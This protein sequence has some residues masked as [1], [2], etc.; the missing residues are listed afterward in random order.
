MALWMVAA[1]CVGCVAAKR[2]GEGDTGVTPGFK[3]S[4]DDETIFLR[5]EGVVC[6]EESVDVVAA[7]DFFGFSCIDPTKNHQKWTLAFSP[8]ED[9]VP[10]TAKCEPSN[11]FYV[12]SFKKVHRHYFDR[13]WVPANDEEL[14]K[15]GKVNWKAMNSVENEDFD[16]YSSRSI[17]TLDAKQLEK[18]HKKANKKQLA[19]ILD[20][21]YPWCTKC[22]NQRET[23]DAASKKL[24]KKALFGYIDAREN[25]KLGRDFDADCTAK[26][27][28]FIFPPGEVNHTFVEIKEDGTSAKFLTELEGYLKPAVSYINSAKVLRKMFSEYPGVVVSTYKTNENIEELLQNAAKVYRNIAFVV[29]NG[30]LKGLKANGL[31]GV[32][33]KGKEKIKYDGLDAESNFSVDTEGEKLAIWAQ[34]MAIPYFQMFSLEGVI[35]LRE[36]FKK[37]QIP[38]AKV[39]ADEDNLPEG[40]DRV[41]FINTFKKVA[42]KYHG[43]IS[44]LYYNADIDRVQMEESGLPDH[45]YPNLAIYTSYDGQPADNERYAYIKGVV[46]KD[47]SEDSIREF[48][49]DFL[50]GKL[51]PTYKSKDLEPQTYEKG[52]VIEISYASLF[53]R[54]F[55]T[56]KESPGDAL[57]LL[58]K[59]WSPKKDKYLKMLDHIA[60]VLQDLDFTVGHYD[61]FANYDDRKAW[62]NENRFWNNAMLYLVQDASN[63]EPILIAQDED[64]DNKFSFSNVLRDLKK[65]NKQVEDAWD[66]VRS[67]IPEVREILAEEKAKKEREKEEA[68]KKT[69][70]EAEKFNQKLQEYPK[71][72]LTPEHSMVSEGVLKYTFEEG[73]GGEAPPKGS[74]VV[75]HYTGTLIDGT[76]FDSSR[77]RGTEFEFKLGEGAV[78]PCWDLAFE[79]MTVGE[80][81]LLVCKSD[82]AYGTRGSP[83]TIPPDSTLRFD[84]ELVA[85]VT[86]DGQRVEKQADVSG[87]GVAATEGQENASGKDEL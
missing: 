60:H 8:R 85:Y 87:E 10:D 30:K 84:V 18:T 5:L 1:A 67:R 41:N 11:G 4:Q 33:Q 51:T 53:N 59:Q 16:G 24:S 80:R 42:K 77:D 34:R 32:S 14:N 29:F 69:E 74:T 19:V 78:I 45:V 17:K 31:Y 56:S 2:E 22:A 49:D 35:E 70:E 7:L 39:F 63:R 9:I 86:E 82:F 76:K 37:S 73:Q 58:Y 61:S 52:K 81:A 47:F 21:S 38:I 66:Q 79:N 12:C 62:K 65:H 83:P 46:D 48:Y 27:G 43:K 64:H 40:F 36:S 3:W 28:V 71:I 75:A 13:L 25:R 50:A 15:K 57:V 68:V 6:K 23:L 20:V 55:G 72:D 44:T 26:C 54:V